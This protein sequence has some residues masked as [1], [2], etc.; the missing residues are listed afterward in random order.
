[1]FVGLLI[2]AL[3][4]GGA[5]NI[6][7]ADRPPAALSRVHDAALEVYTGAL[8]GDWQTVSDGM[9]TLT[10]ARADL[11]PRVGRADLAQQLKQRMKALQDAV[12]DH[13]PTMAAANANW[14]A[15]LADEMASHYETAIPNDVHLLG[16]FGR[17]IE[18]DSQ[19]R[20]GKAKTDIADL[21]TVWSRVEPMVLRRNGVAAAKQFSD[22]LA[23][24]DAAGDPVALR[25]AAETE[26]KASDAVVALFPHR[27]AE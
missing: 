1:M 10:S 20:Q 25:K 26:L 5:Q 15:R 2:G 21:R 6:P 23:Q 13:Q 7:A 8:A 12:R 19:A 3:L 16:Y 4:V 14:I 24:L 18:V 27:T 17:A 11:P 9:Q 22:A